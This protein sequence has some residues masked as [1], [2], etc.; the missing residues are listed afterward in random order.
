MNVFFLSYN[1][2]ECA[3]MHV[4]SHASK[5]CVEYAQLL[6]TAHRVIDGTEY[7]GKTANNRN[8]KRWKLPD[9]REDEL[10]LA[11]HVNHPS[12]VWCRQSKENYLWLYSLWNKLLSE[13]TYRYGKV[14]ACSRLLNTLSE[15]P[16]NISN[17]PFT[18]PTP[19]MPDECKIP[20]DSLASYRNYYNLNKVHLANW[21]GKVNARPVPTW[22]TPNQQYK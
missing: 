2:K 9:G 5:M 19:A 8:I 7:L 17:Q 14:H 16:R 15:P 21:Q 10:M 13:F 22:F 6:S 12:A 11:S 1:T 3:E 20:G 4:S 18:E